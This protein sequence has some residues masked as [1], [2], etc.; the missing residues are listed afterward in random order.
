M[1]SVHG[2]VGNLSVLPLCNYTFPL[3]V[4]CERGDRSVDGRISGPMKYVLPLNVLTRHGLG[5]HL[6]LSD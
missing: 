4:P 3:N 6:L 5:Y 2:R 1:S